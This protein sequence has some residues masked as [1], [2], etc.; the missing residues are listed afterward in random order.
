MQPGDVERTWADVGLA[1][2]D[3]DYAPKIDVQEGLRRFADWFRAE[4][5]AG[6][7]G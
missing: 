4:H 7:L 3:L 2:R 6:T 5:A 1:A